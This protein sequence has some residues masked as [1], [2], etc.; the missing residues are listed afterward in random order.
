MNFDA[1]PAELRNCAQWVN[2]RY[3]ERDG[4][5]TKVPVRAGTNIRASSTDP[6][7]WTSFE[8]AIALKNGHAGVGIVFTPEA[9]IVG[10]DLDHAKDSVWA[11]RIV[12]RIGSY[13]E[14]SP[15][16]EGIHVYVKAELPA[17]TRKCGCIEMYDRARFFTVTGEQL[18]DSVATIAHTDIAWLHR[19][20]DAGVF[21]FSKTLKLERLMAG[22]L[23]GF[24]S[25]SEADLA[26]A[27][28]L[29]HLG[30][31]AA[32]IDS[33]FR[34]S[35]LY[36]EKWERADYREETIAK[37]LEGKTGRRAAIVATDSDVIELICTKDGTPRPIIDNVLTIL[38]HDPNWQGRLGY[39]GFSER[40]MMLRAVPGFPAD[41]GP[42][43]REWLDTYDTLTAAWMQRNG[44][45]INSNIAAEA[46][47]AVAREHCFHPVRDYLRSLS[48]DGT[49]RLPV[50]LHD[51]FGALDTSYVRAVS[52]RWLVSAVARVMQPGCQVDH[53]LLLEGPQGIYKSSGL[54]AVF[55]D[56]W[57]NDH[58][59]TL[60]NKDSR[61]ELRGKWCI[62]ISE[63]S[64]LKRAEIEAVKSYLVV[65]RDFYRKSYGRHAEEVP[66]Q[67]VFAAST[68]ATCP[69]A[70]E[71]GNRR[72]WPVQVSKVS[73]E[74]INAVR[75]QLWAEAYVRFQQGAHWWMD[76][77]ELIDAATSEQE[78]R[79]QEGPRD[80]A[81]L[82]WVRHPHPR[83]G[84]SDC[85]ND[86]RLNRI[87]VQDMLVHC[88]GIP[89]HQIKHSDHLEVTRCL[90]HERWERR[91]DGPRR[92]LWY[93]HDPRKEMGGQ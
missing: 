47:Q 8:N 4:K 67:N 81:I 14:L 93:W 43:P 19:L 41:A 25:H 21:N 33:A 23:T 50:W 60:G 29:A 16:G 58:L 42:F 31:N 1:I 75:N 63:L 32:D 12:E 69:L 28:T 92:N 74:E 39:N 27:S 64:A 35:G 6:A 66:R 10:I 78:R 49:E 11:N 2:W 52:A 26:L 36:R 79:Y 15:S 24:A 53:T 56:E 80:S 5:P 72:F 89:L 82:E 57:F 9:G 18:S 46:V 76:S 70:D 87:N 54:R 73:V 55:G 65:R 59:S 38:R 61:Q 22:D 90:K 62:E 30:L 17:G 71:T 86:S 7:S 34:L 3:E 13:S 45:L 48:W 51:Y 85:W 88:L 84:A 77:A 40:Q 68:N 20:M 83:E 91:R 44:V 37:A